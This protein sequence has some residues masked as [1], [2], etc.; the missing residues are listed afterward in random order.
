MTATEEEDERDLVEPLAAFLYNDKAHVIVEIHP[1]V[2]ICAL[3]NTL[4]TDDE[5][6]FDPGPYV[7]TP[8]R[9]HS[10]NQIL[11]K[12][13]DNQDAPEVEE[14]PIS[15]DAFFADT[16]ATSQRTRSS[17]FVHSIQ[18]DHVVCRNMTYPKESNILNNFTREET[19]RFIFHK[20]E[21]GITEMLDTIHTVFATPGYLD[22]KFF[23][24]RGL[25]SFVPPIHFAARA[26]AVFAKIV[27][28]QTDTKRKRKNPTQKK[29]TKKKVTGRLQKFSSAIE[30]R[31]DFVDTDDEYIK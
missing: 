8:F 6:P 16:K 13:A 1:H 12:H 18:K 7:T 27:S 9:R 10:V 11:K 24:D 26:E 31:N 14:Y 19:A 5:S 3:V 23:E 30:L 2:C 4:K 25:V 17:Y 22:W 20:T 21:Q 28:K 29:S 15:P